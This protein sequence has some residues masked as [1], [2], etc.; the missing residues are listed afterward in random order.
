MPE[1]TLE[2]VLRQHGLTPGEDVTVDTSVQFNMMAGAFTGG[3]GDYVTLFEPTATEVEQA[4]KGYILMLHR[5][6]ERRDPLH[7]LFRQP[8]LCWTP[9]PTRSSGFVNAIAR[10]QQ[11]VA[12]HT[13][14]EVAEA[15]CGSVSGHGPGGF[16]S[17]VTRP[18]PADRCLERA[19]PVMEQQALERLETVM[20]HRRTTGKQEEWVDF[21]TSLV[22]NSFAQK[23]SWRQLP[24]AEKHEAAHRRP[25]AIAAR[26]SRQ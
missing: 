21:L 26:R 2:Y 1:M 5:P 25:H 7:R 12:E 13:D 14:R 8:Q 4:G 9:T 22:D 10:A 18:A 6:G 16:W 15:I 3:S 11:W 23:A 19:R 24:L 17:A 20:T